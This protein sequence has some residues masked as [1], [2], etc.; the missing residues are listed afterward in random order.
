L[1]L[2]VWVWLNGGVESPF[3]SLPYSAQSP[4]T[5]KRVTFKT[6]ENL[7]DEYNAICEEAVSKGFDVGQS[8]YYQIPFFAN[9]QFFIKG[10]MYEMIDDYNLCKSFN[11]PPAKDLDSASAWRMD[12]FTVIENEITKCQKH[13]Q[14]KRKHGR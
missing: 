1:S 9:P 7:W 11:I 4:V 10:W 3:S 6:E 2:A 14:E 8:L 12:C 13:Q 5:G